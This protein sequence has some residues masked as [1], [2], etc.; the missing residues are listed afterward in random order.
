MFTD[1]L[2]FYWQFIRARIPERRSGIKCAGFTYYSIIQ[3]RFVGNYLVISSIE[4]D[5]TLLLCASM[6]FINE[7]KTI[8]RKLEARGHIVH[9][10]GGFELW[11]EHGREKGDEG[12]LEFMREYELMRKHF[13]KMKLADA[14]FVLNFEKKGI[15]GYLGGG[16]LMEMGFAH[17]LHKPIYLLNS[18][19]DLPYRDE[20]EV[21]NPVVVHGNLDR[22]PLIADARTGE[23]KEMKVREGAMKRVATYDA[24]G[25]ENGFLMELMK[26]GR[27]TKAYLTCVFPG[28]FKGY[29]LH[30]VREAN[31]V[32]V[33]GALR[34]TVYVREGN[35][36]IRKEHVLESAKGTTLHIPTNTATGFS[37]ATD[38]EA[39]VINFPEPYYNPELKDEQV[40]YTE[41]ELE[42][43]ILK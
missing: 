11:E 14:M 36:W 16:V 39:W 26:D 29:H 3:Y 17:V 33:R 35:R 31:Y 40:E 15:P 34:V 7:I 1:D 23:I 38:E 20:I 2:D 22:I 19:P 42:K 10:P 43:G 32:A 30:R 8:A 21:T 41:E 37:S 18:I 4:T 25:R 28:S 5:M 9:P 13:E 6:Q 24:Q 12:E 27:L